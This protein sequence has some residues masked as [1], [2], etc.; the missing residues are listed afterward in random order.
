[1]TG[2]RV[3]CLFALAAVAWGCGRQPEAAGTAAPGAVQAEAPT[4]QP[5]HEA[6]EPGAHDLRGKR[7]LM[8]VAPDGFR[9]EEFEEPYQILG[10]A[11]AKVVIGSLRK[12]ECTGAGGTK[13]QA[14][15]TPAEVKVADYDMLVFVGGP[16]MIKHVTDPSLIRLAKQFA[17]AGKPV[18][19][20]CVAPV[21]LAKAGLLR[22]V[23]ATVWPD[24]RPDL[25]AGGAQLADEDVV[26]SGKFI[27]ASGPQAAKGFAHA[28]ASS[29]AAPGAS[30]Q[31]AEPAPNE[32]Q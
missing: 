32:A 24:M 20:I 4:Q 10:A 7:V 9:D 2:W 6:G 15:V 21:I 3:C 14:V 11:G 17:A 31:P 18:G 26:V 1:M 23:K 16:G 13:V 12:G 5:A 28:L 22:G 8:I 27:T 29:L 25:E 19:A 30:S